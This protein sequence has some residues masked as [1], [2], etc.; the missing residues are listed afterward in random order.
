MDVAVVAGRQ[1]TAGE[2]DRTYT[3]TTFSIT[4]DIGLEGNRQLNLRLSGQYSPDELHAIEQLGLGGEATVRGY[5]NN[6]ASSQT[7]VSMSVQYTFTPMDV[8]VGTQTGRFAPHVFADWGFADAGTTG[9]VPV[10]AAHLA[11]VG[12]GGQFDLGEGLQATF[13]LAN[14]LT[15]AGT[16]TKGDTSLSLRLM[17]RF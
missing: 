11:S 9:G 17:A 8:P 4:Q 10:D 16:V 15:S 12:L 2:A 1:E 14:A 6:S 7:G 3:Y 5:P 13:D